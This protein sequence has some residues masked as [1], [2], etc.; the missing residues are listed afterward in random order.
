MNTF[1]IVKNVLLNLFHSTLRSTGR[2]NAL[3][4][5]ASDGSVIVMLE[6]SEIRYITTRTKQLGKSVVV[7]SDNSGDLYTVAERLRGKK[8]TSVHFDHRFI[9][10]FI[11]ERMTNAEQ[12][13][14]HFISEFTERK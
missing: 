5:S 4:D 6:Q 10:K 13:I 1:A 2:T 3:I 9:E 7:I 8:Y 12:S 11:F 14:N